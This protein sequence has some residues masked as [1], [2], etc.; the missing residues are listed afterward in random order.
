MDIHLS[1]ET[2]HYLET[3]LSRDGYRS[4]SEYV[5]HLLREQ[6]RRDE[7]EF[8]ERQARLKAQEP[9]AAKVWDNDADALYDDL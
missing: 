8:A 9:A 4:P 3:L 6:R 1:K 5:E 7:A 2:A